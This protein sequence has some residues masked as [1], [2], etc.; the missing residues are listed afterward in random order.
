V[1]RANAVAA[2]IK[3]GLSEPGRVD[4]EGKGPDVPIA[5]N[6][7][8]EGRARNRRVEVMIARNP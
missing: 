7:T 4:V 3:A 1:E 6:A 2:V 5:G 8:P